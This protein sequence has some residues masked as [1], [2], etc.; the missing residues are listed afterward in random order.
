MLRLF[1]VSPLFHF[2][3]GRFLVLTCVYLAFAADAEE[4]RTLTSV[5]DAHFHSF[6]SR[7]QIH[8]CSSLPPTRS[9]LFK[10]TVRR[11]SMSNEDKHRSGGGVGGDQDHMQPKHL[12]Y[13]VSVVCRF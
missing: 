8:P 13:I 10:P 12:I 1:V 11:V 3:A 6:L 7:P 5:P 9:L 2:L 4:T